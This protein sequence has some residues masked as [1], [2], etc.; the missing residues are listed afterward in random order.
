MCPTVRQ[1]ISDC[2]SGCLVVWL[3]GCL[4]TG[5]SAPAAV[6]WVRVTARS[7]L[8]CDL[9]E[10]EAEARLPSAGVQRTSSVSP[11]AGPGRPVTSEARLSAAGYGGGG[12]DA[13]S[14]DNRNTQR[15]RNG[16]N[17]CLSDVAGRK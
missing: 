11:S 5:Q 4:V 13:G 15:F 7:S 14:T 17:G 8:R 16:S 9:F 12:D 2:L 1:T 6:P 3:S 10:A